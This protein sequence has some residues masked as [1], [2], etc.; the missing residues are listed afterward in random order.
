MSEG[1][2]ANALNSAHRPKIA[3]WP[4]SSSAVCAAAATR[5]RASTA[6]AARRGGRKAPAATERRLAGAN[7]RRASSSGLKTRLMAPDLLREFVETFHR[8]ANRAAAEREHMARQAAARLEAIE[9]KIAAFVT[10][11]EN[12]R[13]SAALGDRLAA[14]EA[15]KAELQANMVREPVPSHPAAPGPRRPLCREGRAARGGAE[16]RIDPRRSEPAASFA[17]RAGRAAARRRKPADAG[18]AVWRPRSH[19]GALRGGQRQTNAP[20]RMPRSVLCCRWLRG[21]DLNLRPSGYE[22]DELPDCSTP[23]V[24]DFCGGLR[25]ALPAS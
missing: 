9:R 23:R 25:P 24:G 17:D 18:H 3:A 15:E 14:L 20:R 4:V 1:N 2:R 12:G 8:E 13:Y 21:Q 10:A 7:L 6:M 16:R 5:S 19:L 11:V 22:P